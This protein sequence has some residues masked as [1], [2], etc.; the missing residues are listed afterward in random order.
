MTV[1]F[2]EHKMGYSKFYL[3]IPVMFDHDFVT[4][5]KQLFGIIFMVRK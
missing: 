5:R 3:F 4:D 1:Y 2:P